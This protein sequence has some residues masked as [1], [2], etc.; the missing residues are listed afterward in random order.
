MSSLSKLNITILMLLI[1]FFI[2]IFSFESYAVDP[3]ETISIVEKNYNDDGDVD[4]SDLFEPQFNLKCLNLD[5][6]TAVKGVCWWYE[7]KC[8]WG[9]DFNPS[10]IISHL[11]PEVITEVT[12]TDTSHLSGA[13]GLVA[14]GFKWLEEGVWG[15]V[16]KSI[17]KSELSSHVANIVKESGFGGGNKI[18]ENRFQEKTGT[19]PHTKTEGRSALNYYDVRMFANPVYPLVQKAVNAIGGSF[20]VN[21]CDS[22]LT[23][24]QPVF[25]SRASPEW[26][27]GIW[28][29]AKTPFN[30]T[31]AIEYKKMTWNIQIPEF[32]DLANSVNEAGRKIPYIPGVTG[33]KRWGWIYP[34]KGFIENQSPYQSA[35]TIAQRA[36]DIIGGNGS[37][38]HVVVTKLS[39]KPR[40]TGKFKYFNVD[41]IHEKPEG[42]SDRKSE[43]TWQML[44]PKK[45]NECMRFPTKTEEIP[46][47]DNSYVW[48]LWKRYKC[49]G[50]RGNYITSIEWR[51]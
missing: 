22:E 15:M 49:C 43:H 36:A 51:K 2:A 23:M 48:L 11:V 46:S 41:Y 27:L 12:A 1:G 26:S 16:I 6:S 14:D 21:L 8:C 13:I 40:T 33:G 44:Y 34:R 29:A 5:S 38:L 50:D 4:E 17:L 18:E 35:A 37:G 20:G 47:V 7:I 42:S 24:Y 39:R 30:I 28:E 9:V 25:S 3:S 19:K 10:F 32:E 45:S 31:R